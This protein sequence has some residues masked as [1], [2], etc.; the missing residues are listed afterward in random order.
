MPLDEL[1]L[2][3]IA[4]CGLFL[5]KNKFKKQN[6][7]QHPENIILCLTANAGLG[8]FFPCSTITLSIEWFIDYR[9]LLL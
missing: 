2:S 7:K 9:S 6:K 4:A 5:I 1:L 8:L 3:Y